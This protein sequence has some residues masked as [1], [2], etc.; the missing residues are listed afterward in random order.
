[1]TCYAF[2]I[3]MRKAVDALHEAT[4]ASKM[5]RLD[6]EDRAMVRTCL[7]HVRERLISVDETV[8]LAGELGDMVDMLKMIPPMAIERGDQA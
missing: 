2:E 6:A 7:R 4:A 3:A 1:M 8:R 5:L